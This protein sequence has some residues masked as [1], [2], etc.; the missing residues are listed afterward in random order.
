MSAKA[1]DVGLRL[2]A[3]EDLSLLQRLLGDPAMTRYIGGPE[4]PQ[5]ILARHERYLHGSGP[6]AGPMFVIVF[7][8]EQTPAGSIGYWE[9]EWQGQ[10]VWETGWSVLPENQGRGL[11]TAAALLVLQ[12]ARQEYRHRFLHAFPSLENLASNAICRSAGFT[13]QGPID[14]EY[15]PGSS[16]R[17]N[18]WSVD[19]WSLPRPAQSP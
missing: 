19:L 15:P 14:F 8:P 16:M 18:D 13:L 3:A 1:I 2:W 9:R 5:Q 10:T 6:E 7:G 12:R 11:A 17:C 4:N